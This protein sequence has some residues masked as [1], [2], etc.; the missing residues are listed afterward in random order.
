[1]ALLKLK[2]SALKLFGRFPKTEVVEA[3]DKAL[4]EEFDE[5]NRFAQSNELKHYLELQEFTRSGE[6]EKV[7][8]ELRNLKYKG[9]EEHQK[10]LEFTRLSKDSAVKN[11][12][13][14]KDSE[15]LNTYKSIELTG[16]PTRFKEL[17]QLVE[18]PDY[19]ANRKIHKK[20]NS[21]EY[22]KEIEFKKLKGDAELKKFFKL[23]KW[24]PLTD[25]FHLE[26]SQTI[27]RHNELK[28]YVSSE[29]FLQ[30][31][32]YLLSNDKYEQSETFKKVQEFNRLKKSEK[33]VWYHSLE[34]T[35]KF[36]DI[37]RWQLVFS[38]EF[39][40]KDLDSHKWITRYFWGETLLNKSYSLAA[41]R[42]WYNEKKNIEIA[43]SILKITTK[44]EKSEGI[45][46][47]LKY[48][49][50][51][52]SFDFTSGIICNGHTFRQQYGRFEAKIRFSGNPGV[53][54][55]FWLV[56]DTMLPHI[57]IF[58]QKGK[59]NSSI[60][61]SIFWPNGTAK[62]PKSSKSSLGGFDFKTDFFILS[63]DWTPKSMTWKINGIP[64]KEITTNLPDTPTYMVISSG[65]VSETDDTLLP[66]ILEVDWVRCWSETEQNS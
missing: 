60:Q 65:V 54:H 12:F 38:D 21:D 41:D 48:G 64:Y 11:Y 47:D 3:N 27:V 24:K 14:I 35:K 22:Q 34:N 4:R 32:T 53:Y 23:T 26:G 61:G 50:V 17:K 36:D 13:K 39:T 28:E 8:V 7:K 15:I 9:S 55:A 31:K 52:K 5:Y 57:D 44:K 66:A 62:K 45:A 19:Q 2:L 25:Y 56:G 10:E 40:E 51:P 37:K 63:L 6:P 49:F 30:R 46:W 58:R 18:S 16:K 59:N 43:N 29:E 20:D 1:M 42:H 33:F